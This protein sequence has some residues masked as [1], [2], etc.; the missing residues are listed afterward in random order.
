MPQTGL[1]HSGVP[2]RVDG[3]GARPTF[4]A[5]LVGGITMGCRWRGWR[6]MY[7]YIQLSTFR[8]QPNCDVLVDY[9]SVSCHHLKFCCKAPT[10]DQH[11]CQASPCLSFSQD[12]VQV[13]ICHIE[14]ENRMPE[15]HRAFPCL[16]P[17]IQRC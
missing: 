7:I 10:P 1:G 14:M 17:S 4:Y 12:K 11:H 15:G 16:L 2:E 9:P 8:R 5:L 6:G 13:H 3:K